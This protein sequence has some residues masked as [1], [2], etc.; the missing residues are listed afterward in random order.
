VAHALA[1][2]T[3]CGPSQDSETHF[4]LVN[5]INGLGM[6]FWRACRVATLGDVRSA[7]GRTLTRA[8]LQPHCPRGA[9][10][11]VP[12]RHSWR[13]PLRGRAVFARAELQPN[14][15][16]PG[17]CPPQ[18][19]DRRAETTPRRGV[20]N[21]AQGKAR[22][23]AALGK[24]E[25]GESPGGTTECRRRGEWRTSANTTRGRPSQGS[26]SPLDGM[27]NVPVLE[28]CIAPSASAGM[29][30]RTKP[31]G[32][33]SP[34]ARTAPRLAQPRGSPRGNT[35]RGV[36]SDTGFPLGATRVRGGCSRGFWR[37]PLHVYS[38]SR[39]V[40]TA[41]TVAAIRTTAVT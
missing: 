33:H 21:V 14:T 12:R 35:L 28:S 3:R 31:R 24:P 5:G 38:V 39:I 40:A 8:G 18:I 29:N 11:S 30:I 2:T 19:A 7:I 9:R 1:N 32:S 17:G 22:S 23:A 13:R 41:C 37:A 25:T 6:G 10:F 15:F 4:R 26:E 34:E 36:R 27:G 16:R 20:K